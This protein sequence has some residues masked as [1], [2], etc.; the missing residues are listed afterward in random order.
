MYLNKTSSFLEIIDKKLVEEND[1]LIELKRKE[2]N[3]PRV[4]RRGKIMKKTQKA[5]IRAKIL[6]GRYVWLRRQVS[7]TVQ[8]TAMYFLMAL[9]GIFT[10]VCYRAVA[11][12]W[13]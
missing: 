1:E 3:T 10:T 6:R 13:C 9:H 12:K 4:R 2:G 8:Y 11:T 5:S 7:V